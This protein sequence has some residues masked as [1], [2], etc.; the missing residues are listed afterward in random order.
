MIDQ[1]PHLLLFERENAPLVV[2]GISVIGLALG[3]ILGRFL[4]APARA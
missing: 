3:A 2:I 1:D 4:F